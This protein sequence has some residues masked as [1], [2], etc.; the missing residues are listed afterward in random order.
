MR[1][2]VIAIP[3]SFERPPGLRSVRQTAALTVML[4]ESAY[5]VVALP[6]D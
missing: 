6:V 4:T 5:C 3:R 2:M 1:T